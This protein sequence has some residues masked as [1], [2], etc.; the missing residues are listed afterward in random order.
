MEEYLKETNGITVYQEQVMLL[1]RKL[2]GFTRGE[3][4]TLRKAMGKKKQAL[5][6]ELYPKFV[7]GCKRI[8]NIELKVA[9]KIWADWVSFAK[10]AFNKSH[11]ACYA[12]VSLQTAYLKHYHPAEFMAAILS[13]EVNETDK[14]VKHIVSAKD[15][16]LEVISP[17]INR[18]FKDFTVEEN[19]IIFGLG[20]VK[21]IGDAAIDSIILERNKNGEFKDF[22]DVLTR[23]D[24]RKVNKKALESLVKGGAFDT[25]GET[26]ATLFNNI[27]DALRSAQGD[28]SNK[29]AGIKSLFGGL[30]E[31]VD[32]FKLKKSDEWK[33]EK[34]LS[35]EKE[36]LGFYISGHPTDKYRKEFKEYGFL[37]ISDIAQTETQGKTPISV[38]AILDGIRKITTKQKKVMLTA[39]L[40]DTFDSIGGIMFSKPYEKYAEL[41]EDSANQTFIVSGYVKE[42]KGFGDAPAKDEEKKYKFHIHSIMKPEN[43]REDKIENINIELIEDNIDD[44]SI[45]ELSDLISTYQG[46]NTTIYFSMFSK[47]HN[48]KIEFSDENT[49]KVR[50]NKVFINTLSEIINKTGGKLNYKTN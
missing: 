47:K 35:Y 31:A 33:L 7:D 34:L 43:Y 3:A 40:E 36:V 30:D 6:D 21:G 12:Y 39:T 4:D 13:F 17:N 2:G 32:V 15:M 18:S 1:S 28:A 38:L 48:A 22:Y 41:L 24:I 23:V 27:E 45:L 37:N 29:K 20:A 16:G 50:T 19:K 9:D 25:F 5:L 26:R 44:V 8:H 10:Y 14:I 46:G 42:D 49:P 11:S